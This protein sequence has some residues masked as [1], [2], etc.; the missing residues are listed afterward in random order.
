M[1]NVRKKK[2]VQELQRTDDESLPFNKNSF[3]SKVVGKV[4]YVNTSSDLLHSNFPSPV[5][6]TVTDDKSEIRSKIN[7][8]RIYG[9]C[10]VMI[11]KFV[12][13]ERKRKERKCVVSL[14]GKIVLMKDRLTQAQT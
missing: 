4:Y 6:V 10:K 12:W 7:G 1:Y 13:G 9:M 11:K 3:V 14:K 8:A 5:N 2:I